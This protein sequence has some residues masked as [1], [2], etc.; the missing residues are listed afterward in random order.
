MIGLPLPEAIFSR[1]M[2]GCREII[3]SVINYFG[4]KKGSQLIM[5][6]KD[7]FSDYHRCPLCIGKVAQRGFN[8]LITIGVLSAFP[9]VMRSTRRFQ[10][11]DPLDPPL[12]VSPSNRTGRTF[13][14]GGKDD[15]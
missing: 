14:R 10:T 6:K 3:S 8:L 2:D 7:D 4:L 13:F 11:N 15:T 9:P 1:R 12:E 5:I